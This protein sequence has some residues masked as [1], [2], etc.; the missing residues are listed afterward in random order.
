MRS[1][2]GRVVLGAAVAAAVVVPAGQARAV[3]PRATTVLTL[4][5]NMCGGKCNDG[6]PAVADE[7]A[8]AIANR[9]PKAATPQEVC[10]GQ[11]K[12]LRARLGAAWT[13]EHVPTRHR[14]D[15]GSD[16]GIALAYRGESAW[17]KVWPL[18]NPGG[19]EP[20]R[21]VCAKLSG[22]D[23]LACSTHIDFHADGTRGAQIREVARIMAGYATAG[24]A[25]YVGGDFNAAPGDAQ[26]N[27][28]YRPAYG[29]GAAG[30]HNE[31]SGCCTRGG[32]ATGDGGR[33]IDYVFGL[34]GR[35]TP[36]GVEVVPSGLSDHREVWAKLVLG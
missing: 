25:A 18:P 33:K 24:H 35:F 5:F 28:L 22:P 16:Y 13:V 27:P 14:C 11:A 23:V 31:A 9:D 20:R 34:A 3:E 36:G 29:Q 4:S 32:T 1:V 19:H 21:M 12:R 15:D 17:Q 26:L 6:R 7:V 8:A 2:L 30:R 10:A